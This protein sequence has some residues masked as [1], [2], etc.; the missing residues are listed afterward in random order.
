MAARYSGFWLSSPFER[1]I[2]VVQ[3]WYRQGAFDW[4]V[5]PD[6]DVVVAGPGTAQ[7]PAALAQ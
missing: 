4:M 7:P 2:R 6:L 3:R 5:V 1:D